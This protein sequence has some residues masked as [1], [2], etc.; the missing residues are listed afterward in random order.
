MATKPSLPNGDP[1]PKLM[2]PND[3]GKYLNTEPSWYAIMVVQHDS[4][5]EFV[6]PEKNNTVSLKWL[7]DNIDH[8]YP[9]GYRCTSKSAITPT[10]DYDTINKVVHEVVEIE[11]DSNDYYVAGDVN[12]EW[13]MYAEIAADIII[14][15]ATFGGGAVAT[16]ALKG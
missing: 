5:S 3:P 2:D 8:V 6:G 15:V 13:V 10:N 12:L 1:N 7:D 4:L 9:K 16:G 14:S 11:K